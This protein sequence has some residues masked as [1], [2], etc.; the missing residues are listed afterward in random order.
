MLKYIYNYEIIKMSNLQKIDIIFKLPDDE[1]ARKKIITKIESKTLFQLLHKKGVDV[2]ISCAEGFCGDCRCT[3][4]TDG[5]VRYKDNSNPLAYVNK[6]DNGIE[7]QILPCI[8]QIDVHQMI[9][10]G[11]I[12][13]DGRGTISFLVPEEMLKINSTKTLI[14][15]DSKII[16]AKNI[17]Y[18][19][20]DS[21]IKNR[22]DQNKNKSLNN[23]IQ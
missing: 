10:D 9:K 16:N 13:S 12:G 23:K 6:D 20:L 11:K 15:R 19:E 22:V 21:N 2:P 7:E 5:S 8:S 3:K 4:P 14:I 17:D 1:V 18:K